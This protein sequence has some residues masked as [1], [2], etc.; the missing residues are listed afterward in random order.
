MDIEVP[1][2]ASRRLADLAGVAA[3]TASPI[4]AP[5]GTTASS[6]GE[7]PSQKGGGLGKIRISADDGSSASVFA[8]P[9]RVI[10][11]PLLSSQPV[12]PGSSGET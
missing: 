12:K 7:E 4:G 1:D 6:T 8:T 9:E 3:A 10:G 2:V 5:W 11:P